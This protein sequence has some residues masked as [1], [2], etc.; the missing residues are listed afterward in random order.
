M[1]RNETFFINSNGCASEV[2]RYDKKTKK[3]E[4]VVD[5]FAQEKIN[6]EELKKLLVKKLESIMDCI[7]T[8]W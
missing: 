5:P 8:C 3:D 6:S 2:R 1:K 4:P 7:Y